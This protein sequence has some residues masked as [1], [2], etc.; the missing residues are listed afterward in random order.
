MDIVLD[1]M[2]W[3]TSPM[4]WPDTA[5]E[6]LGGLGCLPAPHGDLKISLVELLARDRRVLGFL[7]LGWL[8][9]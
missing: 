5:F 7:S 1:A 9:L 4:R 6:G 2:T 8:S 3:T